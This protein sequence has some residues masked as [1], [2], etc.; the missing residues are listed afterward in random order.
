MFTQKPEM[1]ANTRNQFAAFK[2]PDNISLT[3][4]SVSIVAAC[5]VNILIRAPQIRVRA[6]ISAM[7]LRIGKLCAGARIA[8]PG[9]RFLMPPFTG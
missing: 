6:D 4:K 8:R 3:V 1:A 7:P 5:S 9:G 2:T